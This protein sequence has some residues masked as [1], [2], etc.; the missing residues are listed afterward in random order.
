MLPE[1]P[2]SYGLGANNLVN[3]KLKNVVEIKQSLVDTIDMTTLDKIKS[4]SCEDLPTVVNNVISMIDN[5]FKNHSSNEIY[6]S[7]IS[8]INGMINIILSKDCP[9]D[10]IPSLE[11]LR[12]IVSNEYS[13]TTTNPDSSKL[14][15]TADCIKNIDSLIF[16]YKGV[17]ETAPIINIDKINEI[18]NNECNES[19]ILSTSSHK[20]YSS[21]NPNGSNIV[22]RPV[23]SNHP[24]E[25]LRNMIDSENDEQ[26]INRL[27]NISKYFDF[28]KLD[29]DHTIDSDD[30]EKI[31]AFIKYTYTKFITNNTALSKLKDAISESLNI[32]STYSND[33]QSL[34]TLEKYKEF[35][36]NMINLIDNR[37]HINETDN[38]IDYQTDII[39]EFGFGFIYEYSD[40]MS[41]NEAT[42]FIND[43][44]SLSDKFIDNYM[45]LL[46]ESLNDF[47]EERK[48]KRAEEREERRSQIRQQKN[49]IKDRRREEKEERR[50]Q[51]RRDRNQ[52][53]DAQ[54]EVNRDQRKRDIDTIKYNGKVLTLTN[55]T[56]RNA[57]NGLKR[58]ISGVVVGGAV[59]LAAPQ[60][61]FAAGMLTIISAFCKSKL[62]PSADR[63]RCIMELESEL[64]IIDHKIDDM[65]RAGDTKNKAQLIRLKGKMEETY[66]RLGF[67]ISSGDLV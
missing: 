66:N 13:K 48:I 3:D 51:L 60:L 45:M 41:L 53:K 15:I 63:K 27:S 58:L 40:E 30:I 57:M 44:N 18:K 12:L 43:L 65:D 25:L 67:N 29:T 5:L 6:I 14:S 2:I 17:N 9:G 22:G 54:K 24:D 38:N 1:I 36:S 8:F 37:I 35:V 49:Q 23:Q 10:L 31:I 11:R 62:V 33:Y 52:R 64:K 50:S 26:Y 4:S 16:K 32:V 39:T 20:I 34:S 28:Y 61:A 21:D 55:S 56:A 47:K 59:A 7:A 46:S 19:I 42:S